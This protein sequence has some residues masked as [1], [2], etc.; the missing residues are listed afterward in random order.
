MP[1]RRQG[2]VRPAPR[3]AR[4]DSH[5]DRARAAARRSPD[6]VGARVRCLRRASGGRTAQPRSVLAF[7]STGCAATCASRA[8]RRTRSRRC[9]TASPRDIDLVPARLAAVQAFEALPEVGRAG[10]RQQAHRQHPAQVRTRG[11]DRGRSRAARRRRR[12]RPLAR[13]PE[14]R[15]GGRRAIAAAATSPAALRALATAQA[16]GR[17]LLRRRDG[18]GRRPGD[19][20]Q[21]ARAAARRRRRR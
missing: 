3:G 10:R 16:G 21:P 19:P 9:S 17:P 18:D 12:A 11:G 7:I 15:A 20:R 4:R 6:L 8:T 2:S 13:V 1:D 14:A 5:P